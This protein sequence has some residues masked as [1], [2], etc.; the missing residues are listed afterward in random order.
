MRTWRRG[1]GANVNTLTNSGHSPLHWAAMSGN[2][3]MAL[4]LILAGCGFAA[5]LL[6]SKRNP[7]HRCESAACRCNGS[8][9]A[10]ARVTIRTKSPLLHVLV[11]GPIRRGLQRAGTRC[12]RQSSVAEHA[13][14]VSRLGGPLG[15]ALGIVPRT[16]RNCSISV[17][18]KQTSYAC[19]R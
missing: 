17:T 6:A 1:L 10:A 19:A 5:D 16:S 11:L 7:F 3:V 8:E 13:D 2:A 4:Y 18:S 14:R 12:I 9:R 15:A